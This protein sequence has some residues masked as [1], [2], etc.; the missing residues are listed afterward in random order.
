MIIPDEKQYKLAAIPLL[1][2]P[3]PG[4]SEGG[5][6]GMVFVNCAGRE[7][8]AAFLVLTLYYQNP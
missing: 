2:L 7:T 6:N 8:E 4:R 3:L 5:V 1:F